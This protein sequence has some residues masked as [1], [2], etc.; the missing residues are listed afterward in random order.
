VAELSVFL[1]GATATVRAAFI[2]LR[3]VKKLKDSVMVAI[4]N[5]AA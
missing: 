1:S 3:D 5:D 2:E 4:A